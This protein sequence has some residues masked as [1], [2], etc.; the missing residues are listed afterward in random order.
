LATAAPGSART[1]GFQSCASSVSNGG[2]GRVPKVPSRLRGR[3][4]DLRQLAGLTTELI[5]VELAV[6]ANAT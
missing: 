3:A 2:S 6:G 4:G 1:N 5:A